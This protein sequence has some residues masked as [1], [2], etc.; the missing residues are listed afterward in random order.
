MVRK[1][2]I[3]CFCKNKNFSNL[4]ENGGDAEVV[5]EVKAKGRGR[6]RKP[7]NPTPKKKA[8]PPPRGR[9]RPPK[10]AKGRG[11]PTKPKIVLELDD[12]NDASS[13][14]EDEPEQ[15]ETISPKK[16]RPSKSSDEV[17][18]PSPVKGRGRPKKDEPS[19]PTKVSS[20]RGRGRPPS[21]GVNKEP[22]KIAGKT[23]PGKRG[24]PKKITSDNDLQSEDEETY[25]K[26][27]KV[28]EE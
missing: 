19:E 17:S 2:L 4:D 20:G 27:Q 22:A 14:G 24:R 26:K 15:K 13:S 12:D 7:G 23:A 10:S 11:R 9:G 18:S 5:K 3:C 28:D 16:G 25:Q 1:R 8:V 6:P 21:K